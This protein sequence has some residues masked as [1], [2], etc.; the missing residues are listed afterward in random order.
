M[1]KLRSLIFILVC[2]FTT[3]AQAQEG[4]FGIKQLRD[5]AVSSKNDQK[6]DAAPLVN[7]NPGSDFSEL[8]QQG[9]VLVQAI[10]DPLHVQLQ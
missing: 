4:H 7:P 10:I 6:Q 3:P 8:R 1:M 9:V 5:P 2:I